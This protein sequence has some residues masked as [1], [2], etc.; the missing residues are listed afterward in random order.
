MLDTPNLARESNREP[1]NGLPKRGMFDIRT[2]VLYNQI[3][4]RGAFSTIPLA[5]VRAVQIPSR[6]TSHPDS[7]DWK[8]SH[9]RTRSL[10]ARLRHLLA[11][12]KGQ[13]RLQ[14][15][16][17][18]ELFAHLRRAARLRHSSPQALARDLLARGLAQETLKVHTEA[19]LNALTPREAEVLWR[20]ARG[21]TNR[22]IAA[23]LVVSPETVKTHVRNILLKLGLRSKADL[24]LLMLDLGLRWWQDE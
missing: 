5:G 1:P 3:N 14:V 9:S 20:A 10:G 2:F 21:H 23:A 15:E 19:V 6:P 12:S 8:S 17:G 16:V 11:R 7:L 13:P 22:Q 18:P 24:R 4:L